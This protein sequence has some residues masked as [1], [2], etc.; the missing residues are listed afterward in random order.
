MQKLHRIISRGTINWVLIYMFDLSRVQKYAEGLYKENAFLCHGAAICVGGKAY[1]FFA[2]SG[3]GKTTHTKFWADIYKDDFA[4]INDDK[5]IVTVGGKVPAEIIVSSSP[6]CGKEGLMNKNL[7]APLAAICIVKRGAA[8]EIKKV[9][10][11]EKL[12]EILN[13]IYRPE[14]AEGLTR[15]YELINTVF[16]KIDLYELHCLPNKEAAVLAHDAMVR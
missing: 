9:S 12:S 8:N 11:S 14:S 4:V 7:K 16:S 3:T 1:I 5:P 15:T 10:A 2:P 13:Q 6:I